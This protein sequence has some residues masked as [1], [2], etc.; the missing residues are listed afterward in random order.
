MLEEGRAQLHGWW[1]QAA[2]VGNKWR[3]WHAGTPWRV[4]RRPAAEL[5]KE[6][7]DE[8]YGLC[9][10]ERE[11]TLRG[12][13]L[14]TRSRIFVLGMCL[15]GGRRR[16]VSWP[17]WDVSL[18]RI[19]SEIDALSLD[20][21]GG[22]QRA[23]AFE[24]LASSRCSQSSSLRELLLDLFVWGDMRA[25]RVQ[26]IAD[27]A[28]RDFE[29][30]SRLVSDRQSSG[31]SLQRL[32]LLAHP[33]QTRSETYYANCLRRRSSSSRGT[34]PSRRRP[35]GTTWASVRVVCPCPSSHN[36]FSETSR[37]WNAS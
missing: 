6:H 25:S 31:K 21:G 8:E 19:M 33:W 27:A 24:R 3:L 11:A 23:D 22:R 26:R 10:G 13:G 7:E 17:L 15:K 14:E 30:S 36:D 9:A 34:Y 35:Q 2:S 37:P 28:L 1:H 5:K 16:S 4:A 12:L 29:T 32:E 20:R 18:P